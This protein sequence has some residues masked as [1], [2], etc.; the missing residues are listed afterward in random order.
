MSDFPA[1][2]LGLLRVDPPK[3]K[4]DAVPAA[5]PAGEAPLPDPAM[6]RLRKAQPSNEP[7]PCTFRWMATLPHNVRPLA[8][9]RRYPRIANA[10]ALAW[11]EPNSLRAYFE[12]LLVDRRGNRQGFPKAI[13][14]ELLA[15][16]EF[17]QPGST[18]QFWYGQARRQV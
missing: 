9:L 4:T 5:A 13:R 15:L 3:P 8:L 11:D 10:M 18:G 14:Q 12:V 6:V 2:D 17:R 1:I 16:R 7:L